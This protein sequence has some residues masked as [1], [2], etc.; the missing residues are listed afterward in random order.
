[1]GAIFAARGGYGPTATLSA[2]QHFV[3]GAV[4]AVFTGA[5]VLVVASATVWALPRRAGSQPG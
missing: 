4:P 3:N 2:N 1:M 5:V